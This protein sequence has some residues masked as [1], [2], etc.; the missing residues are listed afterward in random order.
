MTFEK[1]P[2]ITF[3]EIEILLIIIDPA[4]INTLSLIFE[5]PQIIDPGPI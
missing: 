1:A 3:F 2:I 4:P 5:F